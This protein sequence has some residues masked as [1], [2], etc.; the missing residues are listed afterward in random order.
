MLLLTKD[1]ILIAAASLS[2]KW[3]LQSEL[4]KVCSDPKNKLPLFFKKYIEE[5]IKRWLGKIAVHG[6]WPQVKWGGV[7]HM[8]QIFQLQYSFWCSGPYCHQVKKLL[9][10]KQNN[11]LFLQVSSMWN[12]QGTAIGKQN[13]QLQ[14]IF[15][16][17]VIWNKNNMV[18]Q[19]WIAKWCPN[20]GQD[21]LNSVL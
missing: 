2:L 17:R 18:E 6:A 4:G 9:L 7:I 19:L 15:L 1:L 10:N 3:T 14:Y 11:T 13:K 21:I 20:G 8:W 12:M 16:Q 5:I